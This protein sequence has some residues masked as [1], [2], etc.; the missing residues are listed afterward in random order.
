MST[1]SGET[2]P[3]HYM[4]AAPKP[5][6]LWEI[7][8]RPE[9]DTGFHFGADVSFLSQFCAEKEYLFPPLTMLRVI[10]REGLSTL[11][12]Y[13]ELSALCLEDRIRASR[14]RLQAT[15]ESNTPSDGTGGRAD[16]YGR[17]PDSLPHA[18]SQTPADRLVADGE[19]PVPKEWE[20]VV[21]IPTYT[22]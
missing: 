15:V 7:R 22:G 11:P 21:V 5:N 2:T 12:R 4:A 16:T 19:A 17:L 9:D 10:E 20:R 6:L 18:S 3:I 1:S 14:E 8:C 13:G